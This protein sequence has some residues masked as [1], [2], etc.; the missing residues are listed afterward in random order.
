MGLFLKT[1]G[2]AVLRDGDGRTIDLPPKPLA[3]LVLLRLHDFASRRELERLL[4]QGVA[5]DTSN[6]LSQA[7]GA[8]R[9]YFPDLPRGKGSVSWTGRELLACDVDVLKRGEREPSARWDAIFAYQGI[10]LKGFR[11]EVGEGEFRLW[12]AQRQDELE[13]LFRRLWEEE[14]ADAV[15]G[16]RWD[17]LE[18]LGRHAVALDRFWQRG[19]AALVRA[20]ASNGNSD[21]ARRHFGGVRR[22]LEEDED[23]GYELE[24]VLEEAGARIEEWA[25]PSPG[26]R[27]LL[28]EPAEPPM[29]PVPVSASESDLGAPVVQRKVGAV[30][31]PHV[32]SRVRRR[33]VRFVIGGVVVALSALVLLARLPAGREA[34]ALRGSHAATTVSP[35]ATCRP[36]EA[37]AVLVDQD[38]KADPMNVVPPRRHF[39][40]VWHLQNV[41]TCAWP[42]SFRL[43]RD[44]PKPLSISDRDIP[45]QRVVPPGD[46][47]Q[48]P[49]S[50]VAPAD[51]GVH[52][53]SWSLLEE[54]GRRV[55]L[56]GGRPS[57][58][59]RIRVLAGPPPP[60]TPAQVEADLETKGY[61]DDWPVHT[62]ERFTYEWTFMNRGDICAWDGSLALRFVSATPARMSDDSVRELRVESRVP[63]SQGYTFQ[64]PMRAP[65][66]AGTYTETWRLVHGGRRAIPVNEAPTVTL[67][68]D[69]R[70][71]MSSLPVPAMCGRG[72]YAV[73]WMSTE[74]PQDGIVV[75]ANGRFV[76]K[77]TLA[78]KGRCTW[79]RGVSLVHVRSVNGERRLPSR[80]IPTTRMVAPRSSY[81]FDVPIQVPGT[82]GITYEEHWSM[83][84]PFGDT[85][86][87][88]LTPTIWA[89]VRVGPLQ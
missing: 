81:T 40:T 20:L 46:T 64:I 3:V 68:M 36:G 44:G 67:R 78:N 26:V 89:E 30:D 41:G 18:K 87:I 2:G 86:R 28:A 10:F 29:E 51:T 56:G 63:A 6:S 37:R 83:V 1:L 82:P 25:A 79:D 77:W 76:R 15:A 14:V 65:L 73:A 5:G 7:L 45:A 54:G 70:D 48:F 42:A 32:P 52:G 57:L 35:A 75:P 71:D 34:T 62:G 69:V 38:F 85:L 13:V 58:A 33:G 11:A 17:Q 66:R 24:E 23:G 88:S 80:K 49:S 84:D 8:L 53:E 50:M 39:T 22:Q 43:H 72:Q 47:I 61:P 12:V 9:R 4:W 74:R 55:P 21:A 59:A 60:C 31:D 27:A 16:E 19:H